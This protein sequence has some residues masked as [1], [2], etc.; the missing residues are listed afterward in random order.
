MILAEILLVTALLAQESPNFA[1]QWVVA[2]PA[3]QGNR[4]PARGDMGSGW[5][6]PITITQDAT[7]LTVEYAFFTRGDMQPPLKFV[8]ALDGTETKNTV[9]M[10][11]GIQ[12]QLSKTRWDGARL[13]ITTVHSF[14]NPENG[15][16]MTSEVRQTL[17]LESGNLIVE[18]ARSG[19]LGGASSTTRST[20]NRAPPRR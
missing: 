11:N 4:G 7:R 10:G 6:S 9:M 16:P 1:G 13:V 12:A 3:E 19:V 20:Y 15:K 2:S 18:T 14:L 17:S 5:G 8:F